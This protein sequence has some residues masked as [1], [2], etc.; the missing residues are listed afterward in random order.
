M[1]GLRAA[2]LLELCRRAPGC[3]CG[4]SVSVHVSWVCLCAC[5][6]V[7]MQQHLLQWRVLR[8]RKQEKNCHP[9][10]TSALGRWEDKLPFIALSCSEALGE[11]NLHFIAP[12]PQSIGL[13]ALVTWAEIHQL[14]GCAQI[15]QISY[16]PNQG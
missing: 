13:P 9:S 5:S 8:K 7:L 14:D 2:Q 12:S 15:C 4:V 1:T 3:V 16:P 10:E 6:L 11:R